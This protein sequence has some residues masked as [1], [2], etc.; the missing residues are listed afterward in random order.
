MQCILAILKLVAKLTAACNLISEYLID[1]T[2][3][4]DPFGLTEVT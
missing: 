3:K 4:T 2:D 1:E